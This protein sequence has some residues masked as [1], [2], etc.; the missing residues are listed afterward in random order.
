MI[1]TNKNAAFTHDVPFTGDQKVRMQHRAKGIAAARMKGMRRP[2]FDLHLSDA[3]ATSGSVI[4]SNTRPNAVIAPRI[5]RIP[6]I[7]R[8]SGRKRVCPS[9]I[10]A[11]S[12]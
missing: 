8:P 5:V 6:K 10:A 4:A 2:S 3:D 1:T 7:T 9:S 11:T 12:G